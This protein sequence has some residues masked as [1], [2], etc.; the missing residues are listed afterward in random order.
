MVALDIGTDVISN[1]FDEAGA[2]PGATMAAGAGA[3]LVAGALAA[4]T[5]TVGTT[6]GTSLRLQ[7]AKV[8]APR[9]P[10]KSNGNNEREV[11]QKFL[12]N[13]FQS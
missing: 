5:T 2:A 6:G 10:S 11:I 3:T 8:S 13:E 7:A 9:V 1:A 12:S 4:A